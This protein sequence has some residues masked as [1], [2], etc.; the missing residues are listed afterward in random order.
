MWDSSVVIPRI[1]ERALLCRRRRELDDLAVGCRE[2]YVIAL[3]NFLVDVLCQLLS[4]FS[5]VVSKE[6]LTVSLAFS[7]CS[8]AVLCATFLI[9]RRKCLHHRSDR[10]L[11]VRLGQIF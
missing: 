7:L 5:W 4:P 3:A 1:S 2:K 9:R 10:K 11:V 6:Y 8:F